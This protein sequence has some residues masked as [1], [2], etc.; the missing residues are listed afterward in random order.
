MAS[1]R[2]VFVIGYPSSDPGSRPEHFSEMFAPPNY[3]D[4]ERLAPGLTSSVVPAQGEDPGLLI[5]LAHDCS[6][7]QGNGGSPVVD[8]ETGDVLGIQSDGDEK[9]NYALAAWQVADSLAKQS[10]RGHA[11]SP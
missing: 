6:T 10:S 1:G 3:L 11:G 5:L 7:A 4:F 8:F 9:N 2:P